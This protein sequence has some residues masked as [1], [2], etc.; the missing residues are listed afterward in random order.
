MKLWKLI[1][2]VVV[3]LVAIGCVVKVWLTDTWGEY[4]KSLIYGGIGLAGY[5]FSYEWRNMQIHRSCEWVQKPPPEAFFQ[6]VGF[7]MFAV[8]SIIILRP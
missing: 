8:F 4:F 5:F 2:N 7:M 1:L 6:F 3:I